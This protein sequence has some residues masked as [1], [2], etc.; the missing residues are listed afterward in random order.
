MTTSITDNEAL[1]RYEISVDGEL[2]GFVEYRRRADRL[3][4]NHTEIKPELGGRGLGTQLVAS[5]LDSAREQSLAVVP[6]C[7]FVRE[8]IAA[9][10]DSYLALVPTDMRARFGL[11]VT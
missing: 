10:R 8:H 3:E 5:A 2:A 9:H 11:P 4:F 6:N 1:Q 7:S